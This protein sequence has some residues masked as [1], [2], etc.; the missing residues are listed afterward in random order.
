[1]TKN[2]LTNEEKIIDLLEKNLIVQ[3]YTNGVTR[4]QIA[5]I[6]KVG[7]VKV[8]SIIKHLKRG[9]SNG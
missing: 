2:K 6:L 5:E 1:M 7:S 8:S 9:Q 3:L 4:N